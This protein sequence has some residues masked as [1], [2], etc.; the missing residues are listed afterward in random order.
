MDIVSTYVASRVDITE[1]LKFVTLKLPSPIKR[2]KKLISELNN[3]I[4]SEK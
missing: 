3:T 2:Q 1:F 4:F